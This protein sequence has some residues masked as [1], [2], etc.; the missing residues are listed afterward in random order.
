MPRS[1]AT[2]VSFA[3]PVF[4]W[5]F[6][7]AALVAL[8]VAPKRARNV[9]VSVASLVFYAWGAGEFVLML[10]ACV[11]VNY[12]AGRLIGE[13]GDGERARRR[14]VVL[15]ATIVFDLSVFVVWKYGSFG[16]NQAIDVANAFGGDLG[17]V[18][19]IALPIGI[20][21]FTFHN[22]SYVV[23]VYRGVRGPQTKP[24]QFLTYIVMFP[25]LVAGPIVRYHEIADQLP[26]D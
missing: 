10:L 21:F 24:L 20:S 17:A 3:S 12:T 5:Y 23:D 6:M 11:A 19:A 16:L 13:P 22:I 4:L 7:P 8:W 26:A 2:R 15:T 18:A 14:R 25:Q 9:V 1:F